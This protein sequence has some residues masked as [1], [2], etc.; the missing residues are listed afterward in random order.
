MWSTQFRAK[1]ITC[2]LVR[3]IYSSPSDAAARAASAV[4]PATA[5]AAHSP[6]PSRLV[7]HLSLLTG[8]HQFARVWQR[9]SIN[10]QRTRNE[11]AKQWVWR[12]PSI[13]VQR[14]R[15]E[16]AKHW[17]QPHEQAHT[18]IGSLCGCIVGSKHLWQG[19]PHGPE[20]AAA[21]AV[22]GL[23]ALQRPLLYLPVDLWRCLHRCR[24]CSDG[25]HHGQRGHVG[26][27]LGLLLLQHSGAAW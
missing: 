23:C 1:S 6:H 9:A 15:N 7:L 4:S 20:A 21:K 26:G 13:N 25:R 10:V 3:V 2:A 5:A 12:R 16:S 22:W 19:R 11:P 24:R 18:P 14:T 8:L 27:W 17:W